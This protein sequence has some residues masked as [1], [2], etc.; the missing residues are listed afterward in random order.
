MP[1]EI[2][3][4]FLVTGEEWRDKNQ[5]VFYRQGYLSTEKDCL[6]RIRT[7]GGKGYLTLKGETQGAVRDEFEYEIPFDD[8]QELL[9]NFCMHPL[10]EKRRYMINFGGLTW[11]IDEFESENEGL[12]LAEVELTFEDEKID[13][14]DWIGKEVTGDPKYYNVNLVRNPFS[15]WNK[16]KE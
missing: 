14:P 6:V 11:E 9:Q 16:Y 15:K 5:G 13:F 8:A 3:R 4:K 1:K 2:E 12:I 10:I 7:G